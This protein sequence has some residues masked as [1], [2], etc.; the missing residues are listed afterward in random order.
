MKRIY[1]WILG[2]ILLVSAFMLYQTTRPAQPGVK[3]IE[4]GQTVAITSTDITITNATQKTVWLDEVVMLDII[5]TDGNGDCYSFVLDDTHE[6]PGQTT[7]FV[8]DGVM[9]VT[10]KRGPLAMNAGV[11]AMCYTARFAYPNVWE[12]QLY[13]ADI[14]GL[15]RVARY[16]ELSYAEFVELLG[17]V[18]YLDEKAYLTMEPASG[19]PL[20]LVPNP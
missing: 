15:A 16:R 2:G 18:T 6:P 4:P 14:Y 10:A 13:D 12:R 8:M 17:G 19:L 5:N 3:V 1:R 7:G 11:L 9:H 20:S